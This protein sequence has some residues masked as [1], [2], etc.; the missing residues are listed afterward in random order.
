MGQSGSCFQDR[1]TQGIR[2]APEKA[3]SCLSNV[4]PQS[5]ALLDA[6][7]LANARALSRTRLGII[8]ASAV[9]LY[10]TLGLGVRRTLPYVRFGLLL[11]IF[12][13]PNAL[14]K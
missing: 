7:A 9:E 4:E 13:S 5:C 6:V 2:D 11:P 3:L 14:V 1:G 8:R 10:Q 12:Q